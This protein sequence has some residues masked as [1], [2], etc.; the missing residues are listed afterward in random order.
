MNLPLLEELGGVAIIA[1]SVLFAVYSAMF[2]VLLPIRSGD[3]DYVQVVLNPNWRRLAL[4]AFTGIL[5]MLVGF[6]AVYTR[7][8]A[9]GGIMGAA[10]FLF[11]EA[12]YLLQAC[13]VT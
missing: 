6:Y 11:I 4:L 5:L 8:R 7:V 12:A 10:G 2:P 1:G 9:K 13:K 3:Y